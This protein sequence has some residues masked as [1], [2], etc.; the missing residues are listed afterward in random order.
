MRCGAC[1]DS[2]F[3]VG[4]CPEKKIPPV[5][6]PHFIHSVVLPGAGLSLIA[7][8]AEFD[9]VSNCS[10]SWSSGEKWQESFAADG[11]NSQRKLSALSWL[12][13]LTAASQPD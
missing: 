6:L 3:I 2:N 8:K 13:G 5:V 1:S 12:E 10:D 9:V 7:F 11:K 4:F